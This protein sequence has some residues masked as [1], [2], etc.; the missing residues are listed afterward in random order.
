MKIE[1]IKEN[2]KNYLDLLLLADLEPVENF[3]N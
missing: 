3:Q 1:I 2:K